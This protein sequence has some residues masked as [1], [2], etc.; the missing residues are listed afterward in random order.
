MTRPSWWRE[1][2]SLPESQRVERALQHWDTVVAGRFPRCQDLL[3]RGGG[4][5]YL[6]RKTNRAAGIPEPELLY[7]TRYIDD[8]DNTPVCWAG[9]LPLAPNDHSMPA[10]MPAEFIN[11]HTQIHDGLRNTIDDFGGILRA[12][13]I[14]PLSEYYTIEGS[15]FRN[16]P[17]CF[18]PTTV[19]LTQIYAVSCIATQ[20]CALDVTNPQ[21]STAV[22]YWYD[23]ILLPLDD[24]W[25]QIDRDIWL[26][27]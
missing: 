12:S 19:D 7:A 17:E 4:G 2:L 18:D 10:G 26:A 8:V 3:R 23:S 16:V 14:F 11:Y 15:E 22:W 21:D 1:V 24:Y 20:G 5:I 27:V 13:N 9:A 6:A 25:D